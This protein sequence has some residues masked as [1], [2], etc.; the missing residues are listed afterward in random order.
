MKNSRSI[1]NSDKGSARIGAASTGLWKIAIALAALAGTWCLGQDSGGSSLADA[2]RSK[3]PKK[4]QRVITNDDLPSREPEAASA[5]ETARN[6]SGNSSSPSSTSGGASSSSGAALTVPSR[7]LTVDQAADRLQKLK[8]E[9]SALR[10]RYDEIQSKLATTDDSN[11]RRVY[12][13]SLS[14]RDETLA[15]K[16]KE[17]EEAETALRMATDAAS[18]RGGPPHVAQ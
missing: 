1:V 9:E 2:A 3:P 14:K 4:S 17:V 5:A 15:K 16:R 13:D 18:G 6:S 10:R 8:D 12:A 11:L 7:A